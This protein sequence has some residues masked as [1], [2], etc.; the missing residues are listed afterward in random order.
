MAWN[1]N[2]FKMPGV[3]K[4][5]LGNQEYSDQNLNATVPLKTPSS[6]PSQRLSSPESLAKPAR[7]AIPSITRPEKSIDPEGRRERFKKLQSILKAPAG[8]PKP[9]KPPKV[10]L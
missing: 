6:F 4:D 3:D 10:V 5:T 1:K 9:P 8:A 7:P 2:P